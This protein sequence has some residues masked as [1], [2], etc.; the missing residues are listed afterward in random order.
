[1]ALH[2]VS[3][4]GISG[5]WVPGV[6]NTTFLGSRVYTF[7]PDPGQCAISHDIVIEVISCENTDNELF[8]PNVITPNNDGLNDV[9]YVEGIENYPQASVQIFNRYNKLLYQGQ[10]PEN[11]NWNGT[12][13]G[14]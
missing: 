9:W 13:L 5:N 1:N 11:C 12:Y 8:I 4:N 2:V 6:I 14:N 7:I 10:G 3:E